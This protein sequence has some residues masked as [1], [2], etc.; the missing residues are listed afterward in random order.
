MKIGKKILH[1]FVVKIFLTAVVLM[2]VI[3]LLAFQ[4]IRY[5]F[6]AQ[7]GEDRLYYSVSWFN[8]FIN[9]KSNN[10]Y[11]NGT[12][13]VIHYNL[14]GM[15][16]II[17]GKGSTEYYDGITQETEDYLIKITE[18]FD[19]DFDKLKG[20]KINSHIHLKEREDR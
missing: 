13:R 1:S 19:S 4:R 20:C 3:C 14:N 5:R 6:F 10:E 2:T 9:I 15:G 11:F 12:F 7:C 8:D 18:D 16:E 17:R